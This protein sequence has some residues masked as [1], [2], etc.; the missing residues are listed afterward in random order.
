MLDLS[1]GML[2]AV[3]DYYGVVPYTRLENEIQSLYAKDKLLQSFIAKGNPLPT[4]YGNVY[5]D[6]DGIL[7]VNI[8]DNDTQLIKE[9]SEALK[10]ERF[11]TNYV[12]YPWA[13]L[14]TTKDII[15][16][17][18]ARKE[19]STVVDNIAGVY[20]DDRENVIG[21]QLLDFSE[22]AISL[23]KKRHGFTCSGFQ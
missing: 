4:M 10:G 14:Q 3:E 16:A 22:E 21:V 2:E 23:L 5:I 11:Y 18:L 6:G 17:K 1:K 12:Q 13:Y 8:V 15:D 7:V 20:L 9:V 19:N